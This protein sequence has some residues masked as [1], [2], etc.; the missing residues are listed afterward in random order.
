[1][2]INY[3]IKLRKLEENAATKIYRFF[4]KYKWKERFYG[5]GSLLQSS[6]YAEIAS[7]FISAA[8]GETKQ[9]IDID[10]ES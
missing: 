1:M 6:T 2:S 8:K 9:L 5:M 3:L 4:R 7:N 10:L